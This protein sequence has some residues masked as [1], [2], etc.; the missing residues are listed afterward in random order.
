MG[1]RV[2]WCGVIVFF[3]CWQP[4]SNPPSATNLALAIL[5]LIVITLQATFNAF[6]DWSTQ[7]TM[8]SIL[9]LLPAETRVLRNGVL[10]SL[11]STEL[12]A[13]DVV[14]LTSKSFCRFECHH[15]SN[16]FLA[17]ISSSD[18]T[19]SLGATLLVFPL[20]TRAL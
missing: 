15:G 7:R 5:V 19:L 9:D 12:V 4:L 17:L 14:H 1:A 13:G 3:L 20:L 8:K 11:P 16:F 2:L 18:D 6:Q 10:V